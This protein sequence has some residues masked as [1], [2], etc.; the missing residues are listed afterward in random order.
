MEGLLVDPNPRQ[1]SRS[2]FSRS[3][4]AARRERQ[5]LAPIAGTRSSDRERILISYASETGNGLVEW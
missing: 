5:A 3:G 1:S 4:I 2:V